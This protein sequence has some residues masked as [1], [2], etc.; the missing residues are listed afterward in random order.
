MKIEAP[1][2]K[3]HSVSRVTTPLIAFGGT[4]RFAGGCV[5]DALMNVPINDIDF[6]TD[7]RPAQVMRALAGAGIRVIPTGIKHGTVTAVI[8]KE[9][10]EITTLRRD[11]DCNGRHAEVEFTDSWEEDAKR[12]DFTVNALFAGLDG[13]VIDFVGGLADLEDRNLRFVGDPNDRIDEDALRILRFFR[14]IARTDFF[15]HGKSFRA[16]I[17]KKDTIK[18]L[19][20]ERVTSELMK[21]LVAPHADWA[22]HLMNHFGIMTHVHLLLDDFKGFQ[23]M[24]IT[25]NR[26]NRAISG[27]QCLMSLVR[28]E[29]RV[30]FLKTLEDRVLTLH[31]GEVEA[32]SRVFS[33]E[34]NDFAD[35]ESAITLQLR[36]G[37]G[38]ARDAIVLSGNDLHNHDWDVVD[39]LMKAEPL[40]FPLK[41]RDVLDKGVKPG[42]IVGEI[43]DSVREDW[44]KSL[45]TL[46]R[47]ECLEKLN[48]RI[49]AC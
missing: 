49:A 9:N 30:E 24:R 25:A 16:C 12:R 42:P 31:N 45:C 17:A 23:R 40:V 7:L 39:F 27:R 33:T 36:I 3:S 43:L 14:F 8:G 11:V 20:R 38:P 18:N 44:I 34:E 29:N 15:P 5:R 1:F 26:D 19:S 46:T 32:I 6:A 2:L 35:I 28:P 22:I 13:T 10:F 41:G 37:T 48:E 21:T 47:D 4:V